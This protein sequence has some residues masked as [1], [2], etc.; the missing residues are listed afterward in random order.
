MG[1]TRRIFTGI[2]CAAAAGAEP[3][4]G[5]V[6][7]AEEELLAGINREREREGAGA[8]EWS[9]RVARVA[10]GHSEEMAR[11][12]YFGHEDLNSQRVSERLRGAGVRFRACGENLYWQPGGAGF[13]E[14]AVAGWMQSGGHRENVLKGVY[15]E[16]GAGVAVDGRG[17]WVVTLVFVG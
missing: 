13:A 1:M 8:L 14:K 3:R 2:V 7:E 9:E 4:A 16:A 11:G 5:E 10:R 6:R 17:R 12:R 15:R